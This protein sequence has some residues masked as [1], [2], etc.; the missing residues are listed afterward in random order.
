MVQF[1]NLALRD[2]PFVIKRSMSERKLEI[3]LPPKKYSLPIE[4]F[5]RI[6]ALWALIIF[7]ATLLVVFIPILL[8]FL[9]PEPKGV[10]TFKAISKVWMDIFLFLIG[11]PVKLIG[12]ENYNPALNYVVTSNHNSLMDVP[13]MTP[14]FPGP[15]KT[16]AK[17]SFAKVPIFG[18][19]YTRGSVLVDRSSDFS[20]KKSFDDMKK[21]LLQE[22]LNM[23]LYPEGTRNRTGKPLK[24]FYDGA[25]KLAADCERDIIPV[26]M[27]NTANAL[28]PG[29]IFFLLPYRLQIHLLPPVSHVGKTAKEI[30]EEVFQTMW[31]YIEKTK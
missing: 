7:V 17:K 10:K 24:S 21:V 9:I 4:I 30:K 29:K 11:C 31:G 8:T 5:A 13:V 20:R 28:P 23:A 14:Y 25:F 12:K 6:W 15:N 26:I 3:K 22:N 16:I 1:R 27:V 19:V 2:R 18:W